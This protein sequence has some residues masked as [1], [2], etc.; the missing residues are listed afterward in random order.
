MLQLLQHPFL[1]SAAEALTFVVHIV[2]VNSGFRY[3]SSLVKQVQVSG[4]VHLRSA[5][6]AVQTKQVRKFW[7][8]PVVSIVQFFQISNRIHK[9]EA[10]EEGEFSYF[11]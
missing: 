9:A 11:S 1:Y 7:H 8:C 5:G 10:L 2:N 3:I 4:T 6:I